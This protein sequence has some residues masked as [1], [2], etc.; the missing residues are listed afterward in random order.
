MSNTTMAA[1]LNKLKGVSASDKKKI[2]Q[3]VEFTKA[4][5]EQAWFE[6]QNKRGD[7]QAA[8][9]S[10]LD[11]PFS[12]VKK[13]QQKPKQKQTRSDYNNN[14]SSSRTDRDYNGRGDRGDRG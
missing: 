3:V 10:L 13:K 4:T 12:V 7:V 11:N 9:S 6:L 5:V 14:S 2:Q 1:A 8:I